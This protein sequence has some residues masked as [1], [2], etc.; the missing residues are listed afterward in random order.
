M[1]HSIFLTLL[2][3]FLGYAP[4]LYSQDC[5]HGATTSTTG[6]NLYLYFPTSSDATFESTISAITTSPLAPFDVADLDAGIGTTAQLRD[7]I[8]E[9]VTE[10]FCEFNVRVFQTTTSPSTTGITRWQ[11]V[12]IGSDSKT[13][14]TGNLFGV[15]S[16][17]S[18]AGDVDP[19]EF[20]QLLS[21]MPMGVQE[22]P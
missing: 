4:N 15:S 20:G 22:R 19:Q 2:A 9:I 8:F 14:G 18:N 12:G 3:L 16:F 1:K 7:R 13:L 6:N 11:I 10:D 5:S 21:M 17:G